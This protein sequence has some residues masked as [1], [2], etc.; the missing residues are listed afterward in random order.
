MYGLDSNSSYYRSL[1]KLK[2]DDALRNAADYTRIMLSRDEPVHD[3]IVRDR[4]L[5]KK[6]KITVAAW[7]LSEVAYHA[8]I[9]A[10]DYGKKVDDEFLFYAVNEHIL[11]R[12]A[13]SKENY[14]ATNK[15]D[16]LMRILV[17][18]SQ[19]QFWYQETLWLREEFNR[20]VEI[21]HK[22]PESICAPELFGCENFDWVF[23]KALDMSIDDFRSVIMLLH[24]LNMAKLDL[25]RVCLPQDI[26]KIHSAFTD[27]NLRKVIEFYST[28]YKGVRNSRFGIRENYLALK[29]IVQTDKN[30]LVIPDAY[31]MAKKMVDGPLWVIR[32]SFQSLP[33]KKSRNRFVNGYGYLFE[34]YVEN[35]LK[36]QLSDDKYERI[37]E[38]ED[39]GVKR[40]DFFI[41]TKKYRIIVELKS[42]ILPMM[43]KKM[44]PNM[45]DLKNYLEEFSKGAVQLDHTENDFVDND[46]ES[47]KILVHY[48]ML[49]VSDVLIRPYVIK[50]LEGKLNNKRNIFFCDVGELEWLVSVLGSSESEFE[51]ILARKI[52][53]QNDGL[54][55]MEFRQIIPD[56]TEVN[57][58]YNHEVLNHW[59]KQLPGLYEKVIRSDF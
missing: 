46:R 8:I 51:E 22:I 1:R 38:S 20:Q 53:K 14:N 2:L 30:V 54:N 57:N 5:L 17:G 35:M 52:L 12:E 43:A 13:I 39:E 21:L 26:I 44:Y 58:K 11:F 41:K 40:A 19:Q 59:Q 32:D 16:I 31:L 49:Y 45:G 9:A 55:N 28:T 50:T 4:M 7:N 6:Y 10:N 56:V 25:S 29:P 15:D 33:D 42:G 34:K 23:K 48:E 3:F 24:A 36:S 47:A 18:L 27:D 37:L